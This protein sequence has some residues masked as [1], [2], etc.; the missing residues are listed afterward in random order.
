M[1]DEASSRLT[2]GWRWIGAIASS[3][4][5]SPQ[6]TTLPSFAS[7][8]MRWDKSRRLWLSAKSFIWLFS[9]THQIWQPDLTVYNS[10]EHNIVDHFA[11]TNKI[12]YPNGNVLW[13]SETRIHIKANPEWFAVWHERVIWAAFNAFFTPLQLSPLRVGNFVEN[14]SGADREIRNL[15]RDELEILAVWCAVVQHQGK[16][17]T[18]I[19]AIDPNY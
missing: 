9:P 4:G 3:S 10:A 6:T 15:L 2:Y 1:R 5:T 14:S 7:Q 18:L 16:Y 8:L 13:V 11:K 19:T 17:W 12:A